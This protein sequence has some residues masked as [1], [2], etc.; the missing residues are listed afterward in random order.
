MKIAVA[1]D[2]RGFSAKEKVAMMLAEQGHD[3]VD[4]G[5]NSSRS[6]DYTDVA[7]T[8][9][10]AVADG[11]VQMAVLLCGSGIGMSIAA[12]KVC[13]VRAALCGDELTAQM[14][15]RHNDANVLCLASDLLGD[16][17]LRRIVDNW[18]D[19]EFEGGRH[20]RRVH[21]IGMIERG[22][23]PGDYQNDQGEPAGG[24]D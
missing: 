8:A 10:K 4:M 7:Y 6:C 17:M 21:K 5:A 22:E 13:G 16:E 2:H 11:E 9:S 3:V 18:L 23:N 12:N 24:C 14:A 1:G 19:T 20:A 15:R